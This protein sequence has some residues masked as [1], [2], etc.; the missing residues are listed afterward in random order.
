M[1]LHLASLDSCWRVA[2][3]E[4]QGCLNSL[5]QPLETQ[6]GVRKHAGMAKSSD[7][8]VLGIGEKT[9]GALVVELL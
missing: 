6:T 7:T 1:R 8:E 2:T 9:S 3:E 5:G 4:M